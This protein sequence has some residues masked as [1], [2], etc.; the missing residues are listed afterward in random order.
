MRVPDSFATDDG[1]KDKEHPLIWSFGEFMAAQFSSEAQV[2]FELRRGEIGLLSSVTNVGKSTLLRNALLSL[3]CGAEFTPLV[4]RGAP[5]NVILLDFETAASRMQSDLA[6][7]TRYL[8]EAERESLNNHFFMMC[9]GMVQGHM[10]SLTKGLKAVELEARSRQVDLIAVDTASAAFDIYDEN[11]NAEVT[12]HVLKP[13]LELARNLRC[14]IV[15]AHHIGKSRSEDGGASKTKV[16]RPR[17]ASAFS[18]YASS[19][20]LLDETNDHDTVTLSCAKRKSGTAYE[21]TLR[22]DRQRRWFGVLGE[23]HRTLSNYELVV[24]AIRGQGRSAMRSDI[25]LALDGKVGKPTITRLLRVGVT[26]GDISKECHGV[27]S[28]PANAQLLTPIGMS[29]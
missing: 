19:V 10:L 3:A 13:L 21:L 29:N 5:C 20:F 23:T 12:R 14:A 4:E 8:P 7:M 2:G 27:Y 22:I 1:A 6:I 24:D 16:L 18:G 17:G 9:E 26:R 15:M 11:N 28:I 25:D